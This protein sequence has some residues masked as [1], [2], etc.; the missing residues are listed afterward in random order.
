MAE[1]RR[2]AS[3]EG[4]SLSISEQQGDPAGI[5]LLHARARKH[6]VIV[7]GIL[8]RVDWSGFDSVQS[9]NA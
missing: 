4:V 6:D 2:I 5:I 8:T 7:V 1:F 9:R 3:A